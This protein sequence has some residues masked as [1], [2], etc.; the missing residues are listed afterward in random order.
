MLDRAPDHRATLEVQ[1][2]GNAP[3]GHL[4]PGVQRLERGAF[5][6]VSREW[7]TNSGL[8]FGEALSL[9]SK[10]LRGI[11]GEAIPGVPPVSAYAARY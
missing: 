11:D 8:A 10:I 2:R 7:L 5:Q 9:D 1:T 6:E 4:P 3:C